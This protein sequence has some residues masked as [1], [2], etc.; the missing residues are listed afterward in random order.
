MKRIY[1]AMNP[2]DAHLLK[3]VLESEDIK[4]VV[5]GEYLWSARG[6]V[7]ITP[8]TSPSVW[9]VDNIDYE[10]AMEVVKEFQSLERISGP[11]DEDW[12]CTNCKETNE[13]QFT[14]CWHCGTPR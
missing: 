7:P 14:E 6:R 4:A 1:I 9:V 12:K 3:G 11:E 8:D 2:V 13:G 10:R 5:Q